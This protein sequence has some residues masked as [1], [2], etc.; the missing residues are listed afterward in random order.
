[1]SN[2]EPS[3]WPGGRVALAGMG[4]VHL[5]YIQGRR[6]PV[7]EVESEKVTNCCSLKTQMD[8]EWL[9]RFEQRKQFLEMESTPDED[10]VKIVEMTTK[11]LEYYVTQLTKQREGLRGLTLISKEFLLWVKCY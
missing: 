3:L 8:E 6:R 7:I 4:H 2:S 1:M 5:R 10:P 11:D 9:L